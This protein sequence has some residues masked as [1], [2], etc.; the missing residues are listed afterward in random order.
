MRTRKEDTGMS[1]GWTNTEG[2]RRQNGNRKWTG[3]EKEVKRKE[4][5]IYS[6]V[7]QHLLIN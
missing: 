4:K 5:N 3:R 1:N 2:K 6:L 7:R